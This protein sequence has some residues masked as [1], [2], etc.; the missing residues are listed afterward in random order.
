[1]QRWRT[2]MLVCRQ[3]HQ[4][5]SNF[6]KA[7][8]STSPTPPKLASALLFYGRTATVFQSLCHSVLIAPYYP[9]SKSLLR[10]SIKHSD[11]T[12]SSLRLEA[13]SYMVCWFQRSKKKFCTAVLRL[14]WARFRTAWRQFL[15]FP[16]RRRSQAFVLQTKAMHIA[17]P[18]EIWWL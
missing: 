15:C 2:R 7:N 10:Y 13:R 11:S 8:S 17:S 6:Q 5:T 14:N 1:M 12:H 3:A 18:Q 16:C 4:A 9:S